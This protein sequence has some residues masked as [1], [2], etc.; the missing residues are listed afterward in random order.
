MAPALVRLLAAAAVGRVAHALRSRASEQADAC[1]C[2]NWKNSYEHLGAR[3]GA[4]NEFYFA[5]KKHSLTGGE[6][7]ELYGHV[8]AEF[9]EYFYKRIDASFC[10]NINMG[11]DQG[12]WCFVDAAC[13]SLNG[14]AQVNGKVSWKVCEPQQDSMLREYD[15]EALAKLAGAKQLDL[16]LLNKMS[17][18]LSKYRW[19]YVSSFWGADMDGLTPASLPASSFPG[20]T[21]ESVKAVLKSRW[22]KKGRSI[23]EVMTDDLKRIAD[24]NVPTTFDTAKDQHP[25]HVIVQGKTVYA[26]FPNNPSIL[27]CVHGCAK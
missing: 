15:P 12:Q 11:E 5:T 24:S 18:P 19:K 4:T 22:G 14:G 1:Q 27:V 25:P 10:V 7:D 13:S 8:G 26:V 21:A 23:D 16:G 6:V 17:Y 2:K 20:I 9:C 3:C